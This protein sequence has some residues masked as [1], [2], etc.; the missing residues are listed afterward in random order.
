[1]ATE[2]NLK[3]VVPDGLHPGR[4]SNGDLSDNLY[5]DEGELVERGAL[6]HMPEDSS[7][8]DDVASTLVGVCLGIGAF[9]LLSAY[10]KM[11]P[12]IVSWWRS[13]HGDAEA[14][15]SREIAQSTA[16]EQIV[17]TAAEARA[18]LEAA[19]KAKAY[20]DLQVD[21]L[22]NALIVDEA[23]VPTP[24]ELSQEQLLDLV[25]E[26][27]HDPRML[28]WPGFINLVA[29]VDAD[30]AAWGPRPSAWLN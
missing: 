10:A 8:D 11:K 4:A 16:Q 26:L 3:M 24:H 5:N 20:C 27:A 13:R 28:E 25:N 18:R 22:A 19:V 2:Y 29:W 1:M 6:Y 7:D 17:M 12:R 15:S 9:S 30:R 21:Y 23:V 14:E